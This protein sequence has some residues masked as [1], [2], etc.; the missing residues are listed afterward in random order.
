[1]EPWSF[2]PAGRFDESIFASE[3]LEGNTL[4]DP[5]ERPLTVYVPPGYDDEPERCAREVAAFLSRHNH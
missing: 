1:M 3:A 4:G 5:H 2:E